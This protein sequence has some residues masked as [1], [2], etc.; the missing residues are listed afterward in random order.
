MND[1]EQQRF[2]CPYDIIVFEDLNVKGMQQFN[3]H[4]V[5]DNVMGMITS[6]TYSIQS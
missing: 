6:L 4:M 2:D 1:H 3:G 5:N